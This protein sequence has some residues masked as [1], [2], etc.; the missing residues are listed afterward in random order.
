MLEDGRYFVVGE[1]INLDVDPADLTVAGHLFDSEGDTI[2]WY[3]AQKVI[4]HK[5][6]P[7]EITPF[8]V[9]FEGVAGMRVTDRDK[10][11][12]FHPDDYSPIDLEKPI[13]SFVVY[14]KA[15]VTPHDLNRDVG[16]QNIKVTTEEIPCLL[17]TSP[18][19]R[20]GLLSRMPSSA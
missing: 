7:K 9:D 2:S 20:D 4:S 3:N 13:D 16:V 12:T 14:A 1:L 5:I 19:P 11:G 6:F 15:V 8:R 18:S 17:Y 10:I